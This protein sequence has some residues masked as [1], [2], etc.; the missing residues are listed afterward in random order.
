MRYMSSTSSNDGTSSITVTF[1]TG[2][3]LDIAAVDVQNRVA[4]AQGRLPAAVNN[5]GIS[6][7]QGQLQLRPRR[8]L[9]LARQVALAGLH[10]QLPRRLR[11]RRPQARPGRRQRH[12]LR[13]AQVRHA[14]LAR[15]QQAR[16]PR[17]HRAR[18]HQRARRAERRGRRRPARPVALRSHAAIPDG[19]PRRRP[20]HRSHASSTTSSSS[21]APPQPT[22]Q[23]RGN[24][25]GLV[26]F[27]DIGRA[28]LGAENYNTNLKFYS[29]A[30]GRRSHRRR[31][32]AALERQRARRRKRSAS[33]SSPSCRSPSRRA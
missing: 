21:P 33:P 27:N 2:Y 20:L 30:S 25:S 26:L 12:H 17:P 4:T 31:H 22:R 18:R 3:D 16:R 7:H 1:N 28:E 19:R 14:A 5:T 29:N 6:H 9:H 13:R 8:R 24:G 10:L 15:P 23:P 11:R 32:P